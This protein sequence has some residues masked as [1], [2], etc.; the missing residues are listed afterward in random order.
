MRFCPPS[1]DHVSLHSETCLPFWIKT[2]QILV[3][4]TPKL[5]SPAQLWINRAASGSGG[6]GTQ[7][8]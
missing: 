4:V 1:T 5:P 6:A 2:L 3:K 8:A 7:T